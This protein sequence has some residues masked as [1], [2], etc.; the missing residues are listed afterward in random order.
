[1]EEGWRAAEGKI[2]EPF[3]FHDGP[4]LGEGV[5][6]QT[7]HVPFRQACFFPAASASVLG[8]GHQCR[9]A[10]VQNP[11]CCIFTWQVKEQNVSRGDGRIFYG[12]E[13]SVGR[14]DWFICCHVTQKIGNNFLS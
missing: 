10:S 8:T 2:S 4:S 11:S 6:E 12:Y 14:Q 5:G 13:K 7:S 9:C 3:P 1:M